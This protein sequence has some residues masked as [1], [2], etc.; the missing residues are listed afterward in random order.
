MDCPNCG[1]YNPEDRQVCWR[2]DQELPKPQ[3]PKK[4]KGDPALAARRMWIIVGIFL[5]FWI[6]IT[7]LLPLLLNRGV[8]PTPSIL[9]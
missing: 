4:R 3:E 5:L 1:V 7:W 8:V 6:V 9:P 2:C